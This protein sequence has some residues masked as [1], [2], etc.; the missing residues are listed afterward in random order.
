[1]TILYAITVKGPPRSLRTDFLTE[2]E[3][4][5]RTR[6]RIEKEGTIVKVEKITYSLEGRKS[7]ILESANNG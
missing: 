6:K 3:W 2:L 7:E 5:T 1:M 4:N